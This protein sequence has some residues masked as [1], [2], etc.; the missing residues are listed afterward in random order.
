MDSG[1]GRRLATPFFRAYLKIT[2]GCDNRCAYCMIPSIRGPLRSRS[3][4][5]LL[6]E[7]RLLE[8]QGVQ[9]LSFVIMPEGLAPHAADWWMCLPIV[10][11]T[12]AGAVGFPV[13]LD[14]VRRRGRSR[15][16]T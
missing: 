13:I 2:E 5:D 16:W 6:A 10:L 14:V 8:A 11:G 9:E 1:V 4:A 7:A 3:I 15:L 12:F